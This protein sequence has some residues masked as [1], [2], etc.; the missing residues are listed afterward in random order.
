MKRTSII[1]LTLLALLLSGVAQATTVTLTLKSASNNDGSVYTY[2]YM[3]SINGSPTLVAL[4]CD[5]YKDD[6]KFNETW[7]AA[8]FN[9]GQAGTNDF[10]GVANSAFTYQEAAWLYGQAVG[11]EGNAALVNAIN[12][13]VWKLMDPSAP[14]F[15]DI[16]TWLTQANAAVTTLN[17]TNPSYF[18]QFVFYTYVDT[19]FYPTG[20]NPPYH[21][22]TQ[23]YIGMNPQLPFEPVPEP[24]SLLLI[25]AGLVGVVG[26]LRRRTRS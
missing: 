16:G 3:F 20:P 11:N 25:S 21:T 2:P 17:S 22:P 15:S 10:M 7:T 12:H 24:A 5:D 8:V 14:N 6:V 18:N 19:P 23:E 4:M 9:V 1:G 26:T 13:A